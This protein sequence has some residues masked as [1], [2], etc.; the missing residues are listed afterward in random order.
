MTFWHQR[1]DDNQTGW[2]RDVV[3]DLLIKHWPSLNLEQGIN[4]LVP[5]CG[6]SVDMHW[7][8]ATRA[9]RHGH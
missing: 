4:V 3:N 8:G 5:L 1:W 6:K 7:F 9:Q 2:H